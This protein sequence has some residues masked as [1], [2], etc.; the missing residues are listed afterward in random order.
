M[1]RLIHTA[2][3]HLGARHADL[4]DRAA[5]QRERQFAAFVATVDLALEEKVDLVLIAGDLFDSNVQPR[6]SVERAAAQ[7]QRLVDAR[8]RIVIAP[9]THDLYD[10]ASIYRAYDLP[11]LAGAVGSDL[12]TVLDPAHPEVHL[13]PL[14]LIVHGRCFATK[15][16]PHSPLQ[17]FQVSRHDGVAWHVGLL[18]ASIA[19]EGK[20]DRDEVV[21]TLDE[22]A[23]SHLD[24]LALGHWHSTS[25]GK[26]G[27][28]VYA[29]SGAPEPVALDQDRAGK[30]LL[31]SLDAA[32][33]KKHVTIEERKVGRTRFERVELDAATVG[34]QPSLIGRLAERADPDLVLDVVLMGVRPDDLDVHV[35]E[36]ETQ[37]ADRFLKVRVRDRSV[38]PLPE[39][40][41]ASPDTVLG[42]FISDLEAQI[43]EAEA[44]DVRGGS[45]DGESDG[46]AGEL[47][48]ALRLGRLLLSGTEVTL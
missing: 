15:R 27:K 18:H 29:Y 32:D 25:K 35:E 43:A 38:A 10:R 21:I 30:V 48:D 31:V 3:V 46:A 16:A 6:R 11:A 14:D 2:D 4:G 1:L 40:F 17:G 13:G 39:G 42:A 37:L 34:S 33:G 5:T 19:I 12:V 44:A 23:A 8:I 22:I 26:A 45:S 24:Y 28:T 47:R 36:V 20:T 41:V 9:G 7:L